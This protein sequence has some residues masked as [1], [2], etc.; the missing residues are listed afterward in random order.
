MAGINL[1]APAPGSRPFI[2]AAP[3]RAAYRV[4]VVS[5]TRVCHGVYSLGGELCIVYSL[6]RIEPG[7]GVQLSL[8]HDGP[9]LAP[10]MSPTQARNLARSLVA[11]AD[12]ADTLRAGRA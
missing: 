7:Q 10:H 1:G 9:V 8:G 5:R 4:P 3:G 6:R 2:P 12:A 11:A